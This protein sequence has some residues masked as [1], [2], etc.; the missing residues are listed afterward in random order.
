[1]V[2]RLISLRNRPQ[3]WRNSA[4]AT[5]CFR[6]IGF[7]HTVAP[8]IPDCRYSELAH[9]SGSRTVQKASFLWYSTA[10]STVLLL[11]TSC[12]SPAS[13]LRCREELNYK[14]QSIHNKPIYD[15][16]QPLTDKLLL[17]DSLCRFMICL[18][19]VLLSWCCWQAAVCFLKQQ[20]KLTFF[21]I[22]LFNDVAAT[23]VCRVWLL[24]K[25]FH[26]H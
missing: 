24:S 7:K 9:Y 8:G 22:L 19:I 1:M 12:N 23:Y 14:W 17:A 16:A 26:K 5:P 10:A 15:A 6:C 25:P 20:T 2:T 3:N 4:A 11:F 21:Q 13:N 18:V